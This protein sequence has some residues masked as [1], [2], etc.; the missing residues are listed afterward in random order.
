MIDIPSYLYGFCTVPTLYKLL[1]YILKSYWE[2]KFEVLFTENIKKRELFICELYWMSQK[3]ENINKYPDQA[4]GIISI[5]NKYWCIFLRYYEKKKLIRKLL[6]FVPIL[7]ILLLY[8]EILFK[9]REKFRIYDQGM[10]KM[11]KKESG[12]DV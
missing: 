8:I 6:T 1:P 12:D 9:Y 2:K 10:K 11:L 4:Y 3:T 5:I 7:N